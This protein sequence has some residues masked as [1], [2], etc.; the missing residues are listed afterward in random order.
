[1]INIA[2]ITANFNKL[3]IEE[4]AKDSGF[5]KIVKKLTGIGL[6]LSFFES[7]ASDSGCKTSI[8]VQKLS[9]QIGEPLTKS[10]FNKR[11][12]WLCVKFCQELLAV[13][14]RYSLTQSSQWRSDAKWFKHFNRVF[15]E[16]STAIKLPKLLYSIYVG[17]TNQKES[18]AIARIQLRVELA[19][20]RIQKLCIGSYSE[21]DKTF[22][23]P[24]LFDLRRGDLIIRDLG[25]FV[26]DVLEHIHDMGA[27]FISRWH[28]LFK[29][30]CTITKDVLDLG[31]ILA[32]AEQNGVELIERPVFLSLKTDLPLRF[33]AI[34][35]PKD[36]E[37]KRRQAA[38]DREKNKG[39]KYQEKYFEHLG[40]SIYITNVSFQILDF[41]SIWSIY[42]LR[43]RIEIIFKAWK[44]H[45][46]ILEVVKDYQYL[47]PC[48]II[49]RLYLMMAWIVLCLMPAYNF[50]LHK[51]YQTQNTHLS[52]AK[53]ADYYRN[54]FLNIVNELK[55]ES[56]LPFVKIF[57]SYDKRKKYRNYFE[58]LYVLN[59]C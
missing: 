21:N 49:I 40:W 51:L 41:V 57:C 12:G 10:G 31:K 9:V 52:L 25:Y 3:P 44:S 37:I 29:L 47:N 39:V 58:N 38:K 28:P 22:A 11:L 17:G 56:H 46:K 26:L 34:K 27:F 24:I 59:S 19:T 16:D 55:W 30:R 32:K 20:E 53:F 5:I 14:I 23:S 6:V 13:S 18:Y 50:F 1:M 15:I 8:W 35:V 36:I 42:R 33:I 43:W 2:Q 4:I 45:L 7:L 48:Q 54:N